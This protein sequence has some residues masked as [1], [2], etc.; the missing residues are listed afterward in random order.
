MKKYPSY[1]NLYK[2]GELE[3]RVNKALSM[4]ENCKVC[5][6]NCNVNRLKNEK[7]FCRT[8]RFALISSFFPHHGEEFPI[9]GYNGSGTIFMVNCNL[10]CVYCQNYDISQL[11]KGEEVKSDE[12][13]KAM[14]TLQAQG[15]HNINFV[16]PSHVVPQILEALLIAVE[17]GLNI[18]IVY[19]TSSYDSIETLKLLDGIVDIYLPD[20]KYS[21]NK[22]AEK[23]SKIKNYF[24]VAKNAIAQMHRQ[25][26]DL[27]TDENGIA[28]KGV[29]VR[30]LVLPDNL[31]GTEKIVEFL[32]S[33]SPKFAINVMAQYH[34]CYKAYEYPELSRRIT[35]KEYREALNLARTLVQ[36]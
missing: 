21:D 32:K 11:G 8:G 24:D 35:E 12:L 17:N 36:I 5:P 15:C 31:A 23:Y 2:S 6:H 29:L 19:N 14:L 16:T 22:T 30:H 18:P 28:I 1:L 9:R 26:G 27:I 4:L 3:K 7:G 33:L 25:V 10:K 20:F 13:A 34:P